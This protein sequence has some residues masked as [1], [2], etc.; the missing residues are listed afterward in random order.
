MAF[1]G[2]A[3]DSEGVFLESP[4]D[5]SPIITIISPHETPFLDFIGD[6]PSAAEKYKH[7]WL[8]EKLAPNALQF[9]HSVGADAAGTSTVFGVKDGLAQ[10]I[11]VGSILELSDGGEQVY[12][13]AIQRPNTMTVT[14]GFA[15]TT[16]E[17]HL[18]DDYIFV[19]SEAMKEGRDVDTDISRPRP[20]K[21]NF[22]YIAMKDLAMTGTEAAQMNIGGFAEVPHQVKN[23]TIEALRDL[24]KAVIRQRLSGNTIGGLNSVRT[25]RG[26]IQFMELGGNVR[27]FGSFSDA[28]A[29]A[30]VRAAW[31]Q[32]GSDLDAWVTG[33]GLK[34]KFD[35]LNANRVRTVNQEGTYRNRVSI[36]EDTY[37]MLD[38]RLCRWMPAGFAAVVASAR[39]KVVPL[40]RRSFHYEEIAK[41]GDNVK[42]MIVGEYTLELRQPEG[43]GLMKVSSAATGLTPTP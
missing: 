24:E 39:M 42:G 7:E 43:M 28:N 1:I 31:N 20:R 2:R 34:Q 4:E 18:A 35:Q 10:F 15:A 3:T 19:V 40:Q 8:E 23:R 22:T 9:A 11:M 32:G 26:L 16:P 17:G 41:T 5:V 36:F 12:V 13:T 29:T 21:E 25:M 27:S 30:V 33:D 14:R 37:A 38:V 6:A